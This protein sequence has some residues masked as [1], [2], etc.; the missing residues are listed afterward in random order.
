[1]THVIRAGSALKRASKSAGKEKRERNETD[2]DDSED[3]Q[4]ISAAA[5]RKKEMKRA[6]KEKRGEEES[7]RRQL[8][9]PY[10]KNAR[11]SKELANARNTYAVLYIKI[12][13][14]FLRN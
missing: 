6:V 1:M 7:I 14:S 5:Q 4:E 13:S 3:S 10:V 11:A 8:D 2:F 12:E 9:E